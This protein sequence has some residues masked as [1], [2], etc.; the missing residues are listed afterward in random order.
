MTAAAGRADLTAET[1]DL[2]ES[3]VRARLERRPAAEAAAVVRAGA[4]LPVA[5]GRAVRAAGRRRVV[6][7][8]ADGAAPARLPPGDRRDACTLLVP[9]DRA[10]LVDF[11]PGDRA[12]GIGADERMVR[13]SS[14]LPAVRDGSPSD[15]RDATA[16][17][18]APACAHGAP[19]DVVRPEGAT[20]RARRPLH[21]AAQP[22]RAP[23]APSAGRGADRSGALHDPAATAGPRAA[24]AAARRG[25]VGAGRGFAWLLVAAGFPASFALTPDKFALLRDPDFAPSCNLSP[26]ASCADVMSSAQASVL[27]FP[28]SLTGPAAYAAVVAIG[29]GLLACAHHRPWFRAG[30]DVATLLGAGFCMRLMSQALYATGALCPRCCPAWAATIALF[31]YTTVHTLRPGVIRAPRV[32]PSG[33]REFHR[34]VP[35]TWCGVIVLLTATCF[36]AHWETLL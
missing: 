15:G 1:P 7:F 5:R 33:V 17:L 26:G 23:A 31:R 28:D 10:G 14:R 20:R 27:G 24:G 12:A 34:A 25:T 19:V 8:A 35:A 13:T 2:A 32:L 36:H 16:H 30:P 4:G 22:D 3:A 9:A 29:C 18:V 21:P 11:D 6:L